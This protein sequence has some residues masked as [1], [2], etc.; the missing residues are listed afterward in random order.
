LK[1][2]LAVAAANRSSTFFAA[3]SA[4]ARPRG[5]MRVEHTMSANTMTTN[6]FAEKCCMILVPFNALLAGSEKERDTLAL[7]ARR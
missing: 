2:N 4:S 3:G 1:A 5:G 6:V 7:L